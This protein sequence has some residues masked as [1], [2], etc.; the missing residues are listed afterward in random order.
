MG[1]LPERPVARVVEAL[2]LPGD[3]EVERRRVFVLPGDAEADPFLSLAEEW[4]RAPRTGRGPHPHCGAETVT[5]VLEGELE[6]RDHR[7]AQSV[8]ADGDAQW[9]TAGR[10]LIHSELPR[11]D[12][13]LHTLQLWLNLPRADKRGSPRS[14]ELRGHQLPLRRRPGAVARDFS[15]GASCVPAAVVDVRL[16]AGAEMTLQLRGGDNAFLALIG[17]SCRLGCGAE[18]FDDGRTVWFERDPEPSSFTVRANGG[19]LRALFCAAPPL[20]EPVVSRGAFVLSTEE[21]L[22]QALADYEAGRFSE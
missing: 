11:G 10:G 2:S 4:S 13:D 3:S 6:V 7:G 5:L 16:D 15:E 9:V 14:R 19:P 18:P 12:A 22:R 21:E 1:V 17:G 20:W 8:L